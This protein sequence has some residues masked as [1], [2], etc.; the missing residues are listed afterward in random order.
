MPKPYFFQRLTKKL[1][2]I[3]VHSDI[4]FRFANEIRCFYER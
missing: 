2:K 1:R 3:F 4:Y